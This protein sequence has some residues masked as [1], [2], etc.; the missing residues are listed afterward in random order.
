MLPYCMV[1][2]FFINHHVVCSSIVQLGMY[3]VLIASFLKMTS[4][5]SICRTRNALPRIW[6]IYVCLMAPHQNIGRPYCHFACGFTY[7]IRIT[8]V[9]F[10]L[11]HMWISLNDLIES[12]CF[13]A[14]SHHA[15]KSYWNRFCLKFKHV[16]SSRLEDPWCRQE[17]SIRFEVFSSSVRLFNDSTFHHRP[18]RTA[19]A[20]AHVSW[21]TWNDVWWFWNSGAMAQK[22][23]V[24]GHDV[25]M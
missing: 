22:I 19:M 16:V 23:Q 2:K 13:L 4:F 24:V 12:Y 1:G 17:L 18:S 5:S 15:G 9:S 7:G 20:W 8:I 21:K 10:L 25:T 3:I 6:C 14:W 11:L